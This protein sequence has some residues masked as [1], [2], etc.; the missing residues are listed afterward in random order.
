MVF[1]L[2]DIYGVKTFKPTTPNYVRTKGLRGATKMVNFVNDN[3]DRLHET[4]NKG[5][6]NP[7][8]FANVINGCPLTS[9]PSSGLPGE[10]ELETVAVVAVG[11][12]RRLR[13][14]Y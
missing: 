5:V 7:E 14:P 9:L 10:Y 12:R 13:R 4:T 11:R 8:N 6:Q 3:T 2:C 1:N